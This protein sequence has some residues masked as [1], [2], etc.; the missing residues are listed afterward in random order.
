MQ[1]VDLATSVRIVLE[2][3][4]KCGIV[5]GM[6]DTRYQHARNHGSEFFCTNGHP[7]VYR[8]TEVKKLTRQLAEKDQQL[9]REKSRAE[10][11]RKRAD[12]TERSL[13]AQKGVVTRLKNKA[14]KGHC[15]CCDQLFPDL[16]SHMKDKHPDYETQEETPVAQLSSS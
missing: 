16:E 9:A 4:F 14:A 15:L 13:V 12:A 6:N 1:T 5:F 7:Q 10:E 3:C 8:E 2:T 11:E